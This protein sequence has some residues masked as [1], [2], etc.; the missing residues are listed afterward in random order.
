[1]NI[2]DTHLLEFLKLLSETCAY[3]ELERLFGIAFVLTIETGFVPA[4]LKE[5]F[6]SINS[7][8]ELARTVNDKGLNSCWYENNNVLTAQLIMCNQECYLTGI[9]TGHSLIIIT[10]STFNNISKSIV[11]PNGE[12]FVLD[13][14]SDFNKF[15]IKFKNLVSVPV[16]CAVLNETVGLYPGL[17][18]LPEELILYIM[19][20]LDSKSIYAFMRCCKQTNELATKNQ[21]LWKKLVINEFKDLPIST[22]NSIEHTTIEWRSLYFK[23]KRDKCG[24]KTTVIIRD[25]T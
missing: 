16:K 8:I 22:G 2:E 12:Q 4:S 25:Y 17:C 1:M 13:N 5:C 15:A 21:C 3:S 9:P 7:N 6:N 24:R 19:D 23:L 20:K 11:F 10:L 14:P 18:G